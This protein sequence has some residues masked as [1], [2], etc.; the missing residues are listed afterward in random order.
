MSSRRQRSIPLGGRYRQVSLYMAS[1]ERHGVWTHRQLIFQQ[2]IQ[3][4]NIGNTKA[5]HAGNTHN[6][7]NVYYKFY[8]FSPGRCTKI[9]KN[10]ILN[11]VFF[12][13][14][15]CP[16]LWN[17]CGV[18]NLQSTLIQV[19]AWC[20]QASNHCLKRCW[21]SLCPDSWFPEKVV[22]K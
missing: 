17:C 6:K 9:I 8:T 13:Y 12:R 19:M 18:D 15:S 1:H 4:K 10:S 20:R 22:K 3:N 21:P 16:F 5:P 14:T 11:N 2:L 7:Y